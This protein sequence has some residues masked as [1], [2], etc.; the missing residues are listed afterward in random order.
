MLFG[1]RG[2]RDAFERQAEKVFPS[3]LG[4]ALRL[5]RNRDEAEDLAQE[6]IVRAYEAFDRFDGTNF[7]AWMLRI[8]TNL[9]INRYRQRQRGPQMASLEDE[10]IIEPVASEGEEPDRLLFDEMVGGEVED[11]LAKVPEDFRVAVVLS[12]IEGLSY[13]EIADA[14]GVPIGTVRSRLARGRAAL[15]RALEGYARKEGYLKV[16]E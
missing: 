14:T 7:K 15:R 8:V 4:T 16:N 11:A 2:N 9:Y 3:V 12:D 13:Q 6:A 10:N 1:R 5:T